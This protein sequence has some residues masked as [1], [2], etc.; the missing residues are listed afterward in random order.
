M[1]WRLLS[2]SL[3]FKPD[4]NEIQWFY[5]ALIP[6][7]HYIPVDFY[8]SNL[9]HAISWARENDAKCQEI[10]ENAMAFAE[11]NLMM[12]DVYYYLYLALRRYGGLQRLNRKELLEE[13]SE[14]PRWVFIHERKALKDAAKKLSYRGYV[15]TSTPFHH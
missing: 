8:L 5:R 10:A 3:I 12:E 11:D 1:Q 13:V 2:N 15:N 7:E 9:I 6:Y 4:S 14:N